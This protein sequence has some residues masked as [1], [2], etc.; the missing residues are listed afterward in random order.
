MENSI[1]LQKYRATVD[2]QGAPVARR[3][4]GSG[5]MLRAVEMESGREVAVEIVPASALS[6]E[7]RA[8]LEAEAQ[9]AKQLNHVNIPALYDFGVEGENLI[10]VS[11]YL[12]G[13]TLEEWVTDHGAIDAA[14]GLRVALQVLGALGA[15][16]YHRILH[17]AINPTNILI[18]PGQTADGGWPVVKLLHLIGVAPSSAT[19]D[20]ASFASPEQLQTGAVDF[21]SEI[22]SLGCTLFYVLTA[23]IPF[24]AT[25]DTPEAR[26][27]GTQ[28]TIERIRGLP[29]SARRLLAQMLSSNPDAR[30]LDP[31]ATYEILQASLLEVERSGARSRKL[32]I[33]AV[34]PPPSVV[35]PAP[36]SARRFPA[37]ALAIAA[38][39]LLLATV[40]AL[41]VPRALRSVGIG[42]K[43]TIEEIGTP[44]GVPDA[45]AAPI[46]SNTPVAAASA[47]APV[48]TASVTNASPAVAASTNAASNS[49]DEPRTLTSTTED[50]EKPAPVVEA[51]PISTRP[52]TTTAS[53]AESRHSQRVASAAPPSAA[54]SAVA[55]SQ[56]P[57]ATSETAA[58]ESASTRSSVDSEPA[59][60]RSEIVAN[61]TPVAEPQTQSDSRVA[62]AKSAQT[63][64]KRETSR[65]RAVTEAESTPSP[66]RQVATK[67]VPVRK[68]EPVDD[69]NQPP[70]PR[71][72]VRAQFIGTTPDGEWVF[73]L[74]SD[75]QG[76]VRLPPNDDASNRRRRRSRRVP[77]Q[78]EPDN[79]E[80]PRVLPAL[81]PD[82]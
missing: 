76:T 79:Q 57:V 8:Q 82:E 31:L 75:K 46:A 54:D 58:A 77:A 66:A 78:V 23:A 71:G 32:G 81:P 45:N 7:V 55:Q 35:A 2:A 67:K 4:S 69:S 53:S 74:P 33:P 49:T 36:A 59:G 44:V 60:A 17:H 12:D 30:P 62:A 29:K 9:A 24:S 20:S 10:Y 18:V 72:A 63:T 16:A 56:T 40:G 37:K 1:F 28:R 5:I 64:H 14:A 19:A 68:A 48:I 43:P 73:G 42:A 15:A 52:V 65:V 13:T 51:T 80:P 38:L 27:R 47:P 61:P 26:Q 41:V 21:R 70:V 50:A 11:E 34:I 3:Q 22:Y 39:L 6:P 25:G